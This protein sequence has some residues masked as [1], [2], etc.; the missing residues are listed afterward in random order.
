MKEIERQILKYLAEGNTYID[1]DGKTKK[2]GGQFT[3]SEIAQ[4]INKKSEVISKH[5]SE[6]VK[7]G[8]VE[9]REYH[10]DAEVIGSGIYRRSYMGM[11]PRCVTRY[12]LTQKGSESLD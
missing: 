12:V 10:E 1:L 6:L 8:L 2:K 5:I 4:G 11:E 7:K 3:I 9:G